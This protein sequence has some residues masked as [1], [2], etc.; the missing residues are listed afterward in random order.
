MKKTLLL[1]LSIATL[2]SCSD[3]KKQEQSTNTT[4]AETLGKTN[5]ETFKAVEHIKAESTDSI[6][7]ASFSVKIPLYVQPNKVEKRFNASVLSMFAQDSVQSTADFQM[8]MNELLS[9]Y[10]QTKKEFP[11]MPGGWYLQNDVE[12]TYRSEK[13]WAFTKTTSE[14]TGGAHGNYSVTYANF[15]PATGKKLTLKEVFKEE[16][17]NKLTELAEKA[18]REDR[19]IK[20]SSSLQQLGYTF[21]DGQFQLSE[22]FLLTDDGIRFFYNAYEVA[23]YAMGTAKADLSLEQ[24]QSGLKYN[25]IK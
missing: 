8:Q 13:V 25:W 4:T 14:F 9:E 21:K 23:P 17:M 15:I 24:I 10:L 12:L 6:T 11:E 3:D 16:F 20:D 18:F 22:N 2:F 7:P 19:N 5:Y 1:L